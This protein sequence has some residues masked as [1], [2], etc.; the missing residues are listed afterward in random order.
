VKGDEFIAQHGESNY[1]VLTALTLAKDAASH[2]DWGKAESYLSTAI[3]KAQSDALKGIAVIRKARV[4]LQQD[5]VDAALATLATTLPASYK[6][7][8]EETK[9]DAYLKQGKAELARNAY[10]AAIDAS[11]EQVAPVLQMKL[12]DLAENITLAN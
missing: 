9:G 3:E 8:I 2:K 1:A 7:S 5:N 4:Q 12:D 10:Q 11:G 6:A